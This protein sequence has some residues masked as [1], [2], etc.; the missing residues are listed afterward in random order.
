MLNKLKSIHEEELIE[1]VWENEE[2][3]IDYA[4]NNICANEMLKIIKE[5]NCMCAEIIDFIEELELLL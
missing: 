5:K 1:F 4:L 3:L 2:E